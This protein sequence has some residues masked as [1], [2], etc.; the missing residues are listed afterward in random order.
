MQFIPGSDAKDQL[1][2]LIEEVEGVALDL[3]AI[4]KDKESGWDIDD[5]IDKLSDLNLRLEDIRDDLEIE[6]E[7]EEG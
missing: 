7:K 6:N 4:L 5:S 2:E 1:E 3:K